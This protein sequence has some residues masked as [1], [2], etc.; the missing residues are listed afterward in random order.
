MLEAEIIRG[1]AVFRRQI[2]LNDAVLNKGGAR[3]NHGCGTSRRR[4]IRYD[5]QIRRPD[6]LDSYRIHC[7]IPCWRQEDAIVYP[8]VE[9][10]IVTPICPHT[11]TNRPLVIPDSA[12]VEIDF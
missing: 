1:G 5:L 6:S 8:I 9:A 10:F 4:R 12:K 7:R 11:S 3:S 2:A